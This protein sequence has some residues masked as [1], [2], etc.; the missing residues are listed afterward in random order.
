MAKDPTTAHPMLDVNLAESHFDS[1][2]LEI[3]SFSADWLYQVA[4]SVIWKFGKVVT[5]GSPKERKIEEALPPL[6]CSLSMQAVLSLFNDQIASVI[7]TG[8]TR[9]LSDDIPQAVNGVLASLPTH[10]VVQV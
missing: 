3:H 4:I 6:H 7:H 10:V 1:V 9:A 2:S 5:R 8:I